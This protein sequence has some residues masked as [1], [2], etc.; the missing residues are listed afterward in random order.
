ME[1]PGFN[2]QPL[3]FSGA[4]R[5]EPRIIDGENMARNEDNGEREN[6]LKEQLQK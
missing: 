3:E 2:D 4:M 1:P 5:N 6:F